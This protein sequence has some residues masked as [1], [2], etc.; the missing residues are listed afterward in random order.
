MAVQVQFRRGTTT[1]TSTF[2]GA[3]GEITIDTT[4]NTVVVHDGVKVSGYPLSP[5]T[6]F[7]V[8]NAA[9]NS[10]NNVAPQVAPAFNTANA[11]FG[12]ANTV[13]G[14]ANTVGTYANTAGS[15]A[16]QAGVIANAAFGKANSAIANTS[17]VVF[18]GNISFVSGNVS[19]GTV[20]PAANLYVVGSSATP[21][22]TLV[23]GATITPVFSANNNFTVTL[24]GNRTMANP[25][26]PIAGQSGVIAIIQDATGSRTL[27]WGSY[28]RFQGNTA[29]TLSTSANSVDLLSYYVRTTSNISAQLVTNIG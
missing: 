26:G 4:K 24:G 8:A 5:N 2:T 20:T 18:S 19:I 17:G 6:A 15:Y 3:A 13:G 10:A 12:S 1:Q 28:W 21:A 27:S 16:N 29:P 25:T 22:N 7:D 9:F 23:D 14:Y 11:A